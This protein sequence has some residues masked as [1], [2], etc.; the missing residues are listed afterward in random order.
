MNSYCEQTGW[1]VVTFGS[2]IPCLGI[3][4]ASCRKSHLCVQ[5]GI[6]KCNKGVELE[7][8][9]QPNKEDPT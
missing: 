9:E 8:P 4:D 2:Y 7:I 5:Q 1:D 6:L 3:N